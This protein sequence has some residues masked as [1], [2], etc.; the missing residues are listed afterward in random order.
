MHIIKA[1]RVGPVTADAHSRAAFIVES[2]VGEID[3]LSSDQVIVAADLEIIFESLSGIPERG[4]GPV[5]HVF[6]PRKVLTPI[7]E[8][9]RTAGE[10]G[11]FPLLFC[12]QGYVQAG[13]FREPLTE[14]HRPVP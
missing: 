11:G 13:F 12:G 3:P 14:G 10:A 9:P 7:M 6:P 2:A 5:S 8:R 4:E 1:E